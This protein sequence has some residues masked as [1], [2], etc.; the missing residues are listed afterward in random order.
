MKIDLCTTLPSVIRAS[1]RR[2]VLIP[3][4]LLFSGNSLAQFAYQCDRPNG[5]TF[6]SKSPCPTGMTWTRIRT[7]PY[8]TGPDPLSGV[9]PVENQSQNQP[10]RPSAKG[11]AAVASTGNPEYDQALEEYRHAIKHG[12]LGDYAATRQKLKML[13]G[14]RS[15]QSSYLVKDAYGNYRKSD[16]CFMTKDAFGNLRWSRAGC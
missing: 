10:K 3:L 1:M 12:D 13:S 15:D 16:D 7:D 8:Y 6:L 11:K 5:T 4:T 9:K 2:L 14:E